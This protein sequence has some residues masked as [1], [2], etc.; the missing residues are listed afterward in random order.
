MIA[1]IQNLY[2]RRCKPQSRSPFIIA[3]SELVDPVH[4][5][6]HYQALEV[7]RHVF[8]GLLEDSFLDLL[9]MDSRLYVLRAYT[10][11]D[12]DAY[13]LFLSS[14][15]E[16]ASSIFQKFPSPLFRLSDAVFRNSAV[17]RCGFSCAAMLQD[18][19]GRRC[20]ICKQVLD[21]AGHERCCDPAK[22]LRGQRHRDVKLCASSMV[23]SVP[24][25]MSRLEQRLP[26]ANGTNLQPDL[27]VA[28]PTAL[29]DADPYSRHY[30]D[31]TVW[32]VSA[33]SYHRAAMK[34][35]VQLVAEQAK[36]R[37]YGAFAQHR[38]AKFGVSASPA[39]VN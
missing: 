39:S 14:A 27:T 30:V 12:Q 35:E 33:K 3:M 31:V 25:C 38:N 9:T 8:L 20:P 4:S 21:E 19:F 1:L 26:D 11:N 5:T 7:F 16:S 36:Q 28:L 29:G 32:D 22:C 2:S 34:G 24:F 13:K 15:T 17:L 6:L 18:I 10:Y 23:N 37:K